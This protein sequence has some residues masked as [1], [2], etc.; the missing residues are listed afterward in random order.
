SLFIYPYP[1]IPKLIA[2]ASL[3]LVPT[4]CWSEPMTPLLARAC[5]SCLPR[6]ELVAHNQI[7]KSEK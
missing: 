4:P 1:K 2:S 5:S 6:I 7:G 3:W